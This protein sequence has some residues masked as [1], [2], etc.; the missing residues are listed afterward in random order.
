MP[1]TCGAGLPRERAA[2]RPVARDAPDG[3]RARRKVIALTRRS[4]DPV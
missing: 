2:V 1:M 4:V 3:T